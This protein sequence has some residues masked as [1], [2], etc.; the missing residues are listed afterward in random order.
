[1]HHGGRIRALARV[2]A[3]PAAV[4]CPGCSSTTSCDKVRRPFSLRSDQHPTVVGD[5]AGAPISLR[6]SA[7][8]P[9]ARQSIPLGY[10][11]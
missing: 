3:M 2:R 7:T 11:P 1:M 8:Y 4:V 6:Q 10:E 5:V 9:V